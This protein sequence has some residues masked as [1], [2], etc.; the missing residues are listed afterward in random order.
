MTKEFTYP[1]SA[2]VKKLADKI[3]SHGLDERVAKAI[4]RVVVEPD[5]FRKK[6]L[7]PTRQRIKG[8]TL[9]IIQTDVFTLGVVPFVCNPRVQE[10]WALPA[11]GGTNT[12]RPLDHPTGVTHN[13]HAAELIAHAS[14]VEQIKSLQTSNA[15]AVTRMN[16]YESSVSSTGVLQP[17]VL[18][19]MTLHVDGRTPVTFLTSIDGSSRTSAAHQTLGVR[20]DEAIFPLAVADKVTTRLAA[21]IREAHGDERESRVNAATLPATIII[22]YEPDPGEAPDYPGAI[23]SLLS[24]FH[25]DIPQQWSH[26]AQ[27]EL[28]ARKAVDALIADGAWTA[29]FGQWALGRMDPSTA[30]SHGFLTR[31]DER[32]VVVEKA[33]MHP[34]ALQSVNKGIRSILVKSECKREY[35]MGLATELALLSIRHKYNPD[36]MKSVR[37]AF[38]KLISI[39]GMFPTRAREDCWSVTG[40]DPDDILADALDELKTDELSSR[41]ELLALGMWNLTIHGSVTRGRDLEPVK[42]ANK[43][44]STEHGLRILHRAIVDGRAGGDKMHLVDVTGAV[45]SDDTD[46]PVDLKKVGVRGLMEILDRGDGPPGPVSDDPLV[47]LHETVTHCLETIAKL[48]YFPEE[49]AA[50]CDDDGNALVEKFGVDP[51]LVA[52]AAKVLDDVRISLM[53][54]AST[55]RKAAES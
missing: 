43:L 1:K 10:T 6:L 36:D 53:G 35:R 14:S 44:V 13:S 23:D 34:D 25:V 28:I 19:P 31:P 55:A 46:R 11:A 24:L 50:I 52:P 7:S 22:G 26:G 41:M 45:I 3:E 33:F 48:A 18:S 47:V 39:K 51:Q 9:S 12:H 21:A 8:G 4:A 38:V 42:L 17:V 49:L 30:A 5:E 29:E 40:R 32:G 16:S 54:Y 2:S 20:A 37:S 27:R 15:A